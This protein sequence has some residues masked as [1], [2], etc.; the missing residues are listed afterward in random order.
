M[1]GRGVVNKLPVLIVLVVVG[2]LELQILKI[3]EVKNQPKRQGTVHQ[4]NVNF[5]AKPEAKALQNQQW[6]I[7]IV[8]QIIPP[9]IDYHQH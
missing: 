5:Q 9:D 3:S 4:G 6:I 1:F 7:I 2:I 8:L